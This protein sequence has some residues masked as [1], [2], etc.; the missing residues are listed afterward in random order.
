MHNH[1][2]FIW[3]SKSR[4]FTPLATRPA[5]FFLPLAALIQSAVACSTGSSRHRTSPAFTPRSLSLAIMPRN[6]GD[7]QWLNTD[8]RKG[9]VQA[10]IGAAGLIHV[11]KRKKS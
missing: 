6:F 1:T 8:D 2:A 3:T 11:P 9:A 4:T 5:G 10:K 7:E